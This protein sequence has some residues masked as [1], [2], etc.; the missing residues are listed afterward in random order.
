MVRW[1][2]KKV[3]TVHSTGRARQ[4]AASDPASDGQPAETGQLGPS[5]RQ[6]L[7]EHPHQAGAGASDQSTNY[8]INK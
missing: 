3:S 8:P 1:L 7:A 4:A 2:I 6:D 5:D